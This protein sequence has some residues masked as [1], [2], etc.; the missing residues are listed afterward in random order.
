MLS[1]YGAAMMSEELLGLGAD[2]YVQKG[3]SMR[4]IVQYI[5][6]AIEPGPLTKPGPVMSLVPLG[7]ARHDRGR[8]GRVTELSPAIAARLKR[9]ADGPGACDRAAARH[10]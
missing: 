8:L 7:W 9:D 4:R 1:A 10:R 6:D 5:E 3:F 2:G